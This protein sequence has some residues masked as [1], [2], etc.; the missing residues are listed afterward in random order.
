MTLTCPETGQVV[1]VQRPGPEFTLRA[2]RIAK[3]FSQNQA[4]DPKQ[5]EGLSDEER[6]QK[7]LAEMSDEELENR[8]VF[9]R[10]LVV[11]MCKSPKL[12]HHPKP[13]SNEIGPDDIGDDFWFLF[14]HA[15]TNY[16]GL[17]I[18]VADT[19]VEGVDLETFREESGVSGDSV[20]SVLLP[21]GDEQATTDQGL[22]DSAGVG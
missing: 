17:K 1:Q 3:T 20:D 10:E 11:A 5:Y 18:P 4:D 9:A 19:E 13:D 12:V 21:R 22:V 8:V 16:Y 6:G 2:G 15:M 7:I 14:N